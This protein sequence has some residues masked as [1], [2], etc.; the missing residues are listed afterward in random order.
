MKKGAV[1][2][3]HP[4]TKR[5]PPQCKPRGPQRSTQ[6]HQTLQSAILHGD[7]GENPVS[8]LLTSRSGSEIIRDE[9][10][11]SQPIVGT[12]RCPVINSSTPLCNKRKT[13][14]LHTQSGHPSRVCILTCSI[15]F[16]RVLRSGNADPKGP[17]GQ[18]PLHICAKVIH[19]VTGL[20]RVARKS[21]RRCDALRKWCICWYERQRGRHLPSPCSTKRRFGND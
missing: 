16:F 19:L 12:P 3:R 9:E 5:A 11:V 6:V 8:L 13:R 7:Y 2:K 20:T 18:T 21:R 4:T 15:S 17:G 10:V 1:P 14:S